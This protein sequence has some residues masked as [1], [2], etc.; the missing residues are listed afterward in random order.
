MLIKRIDLENLEEFIKLNKEKY[1]NDLLYN[2]NFKNILCQKSFIWN[3]IH[4]KEFKDYYKESI[5]YNI[6]LSSINYFEYRNEIY[7]FDLENYYLIKLKKIYYVIPQNCCDIQII[8]N[9]ISLKKEIKISNSLKS[10]DIIDI[11]DCNV[12]LES[13]QLEIKEIKEE[14]NCEIKK[15]NNQLEKIKIDIENKKEEMKKQIENLKDKIFILNSNLLKY[16]TLFGDSFEIQQLRSGK[17]SNK[18]TP[19]I[20]YQK[21][22]FLDEEMI[23][24]SNISYDNW[25]VNYES[26]AEFFKEYDLAV[27]IFCPTEKCISV[28]RN[29]SQKYASLYNVYGKLINE[30]EFWRANQ[31]G[32]LI[33]D[34]ENLWLVWVDEEITINNDLFMTDKS[35]NNEN[36]INLGQT[37]L[38]SYQSLNIRN[39]DLLLLI[40]KMLISDKLIELNNINNDLDIFNHEQIVISSADNFIDDNRYPSL[41]KFMYNTKNNLGDKIFLLKTIT[42]ERWDSYLNKYVDSSYGIYNRGYNAEIEKHSITKISK[43]ENDVYYKNYKNY[44]ILAP[45]KKWSKKYND[46]KTR[47][48]NIEIY[49]DEFINLKYVTLDMVNYWIDSKNVGNFKYVEIINALKE[50]KRY[51]I[52]IR[53]K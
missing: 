26:I 47:N 27:N 34:G 39:R 4:F 40:I 24:M 41:S 16:R 14:Y 9:E 19:L 31:I 51:L 20:I 10:I 30:I 48:V 25:E 35:I 23:R 12:D 32:I 29:A 46:Y 5:K 1:Y 44:Y 36:T 11:F 15:L 3:D 43:I 22:R 33:K 50:L 53:G 52:N 18:D 7:T 37:R 28:F 17:S 21:F 6:K 38:R 2:N 42:G 45:S 49:S 13:A 8:N